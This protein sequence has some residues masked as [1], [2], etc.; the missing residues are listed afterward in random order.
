MLRF[1]AGLL[2]IGEG[3]ASFFDF[4][5]D[6]NYS[7]YQSTRERVEEKLGHKV[8]FRTEEEAMEADSEELRKDFEKVLGK[9]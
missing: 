3:F 7:S 8:V 9:W 5:P 6:P 2:S 1:F 4:F